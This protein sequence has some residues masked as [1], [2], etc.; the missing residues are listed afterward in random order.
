MVSQARWMILPLILMAI[1]GGIGLMQ[2][3]KAKVT[4]THDWKEAED[5]AF[6]TVVQVVAQHTTLNWLE[7]YKAPRQSE[8]YGTAFFI[9]A[10]G[11]LLTNFH[12]VD[13]AKSVHVHVPVL[14]LKPIEATIIGVCPEADVALIKLKDEG[15]KF[16]RKALK[17]ISFLTLGDSDALFA[18]EPVLA[19]GY[20]LGQRY[21]K[22]TVGVVAGREYING[23]S[24]MH[25]T[26]PINPGNSGGP[27][28]NLDGQVVGINSAIIENSQNIGYI[29]PIYDAQ[30]LLKDL[31]C[32][33]LVRKPSLGINYNTTTDEHAQLLGNP[34]PAGVYINTVDRDSVA[35]KAGLKSGDMLYAINNHVIDSYGDVSVDWQSSSK[36]TLDEFLIR[37]PLNEKLTLRIYRNGKEKIVKCTYSAPVP[38]PIRFV[39]P[40][41]EPK[42]V[43]YEIIG[44][45]CVMQLRLNHLDFFERLIPLHEYRLNDSQHKEVL[46]ITKLLPGSTIHKINCF[47]EGAL[48]TE[49]NGKHIKNLSDLRK[50]LKG[51]ANT[52]VI[53][54]KSKDKIA[55]AVSVDALLKD[56]DRITRDF[57][58]NSTQAIKDLKK[59]RSGFL[60]QKQKT[61][62]AHAKDSVNR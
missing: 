3:S 49:V 23:R 30:I 16:M 4:R 20:P 36:V 18:T 45:M 11:T 41:F 14:G 12:V 44:G 48:L 33:K 7:P 2:V 50:A 27:L 40:D 43:D 10:E 13:Q 28:L 52:G 26:A 37:L 17:S 25:V 61:T 57:M 6:N 15:L 51:S 47:Y 59:E 9:D 53:S 32:T 22:S 39:Y 58:F 8:G 46:V 21:I 1:V 19:L 55:T 35:A 60:G 24:Y 56:E 38:Q 5:R 54:F 62:T 31:A 29:V 34:L 42:E